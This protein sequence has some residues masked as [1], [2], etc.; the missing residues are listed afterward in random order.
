GGD[1]FVVASDLLALCP[2][3]E[4]AL[5]S[6]IRTSA[7]AI[8]IQADIGEV[9][10]APGESLEELLVAADEAMYRKKQPTRTLELPAPGT[11][12]YLRADSAP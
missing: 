7:G 8:T 3:L 5:L 12:R 1:E 10:W 2:R 6:P 4:A 11:A 9:K